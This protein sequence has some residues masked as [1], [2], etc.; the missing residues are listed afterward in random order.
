MQ[1]NIEQEKEQFDK[2][3][4]NFANNDDFIEQHN[5]LDLSYTLGLNQFSAMSFEEWR[6]YVGLKNPEIS[7]AHDHADSIHKAPAEEVTLP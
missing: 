4:Q 1:C 5:A 7:M 2:M 3:L 6:D